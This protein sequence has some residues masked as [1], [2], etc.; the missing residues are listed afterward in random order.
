[1]IDD[2]VR[3]RRYTLRTCSSISLL[4][5]TDTSQRSRQP[6]TD[7]TSYK[8]LAWRNRE[9]LEFVLFSTNVDTAPAALKTLVPLESLNIRHVY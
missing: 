3:R 6:I 4:F 7:I 9:S 1:M 8:T 2:K 5:T